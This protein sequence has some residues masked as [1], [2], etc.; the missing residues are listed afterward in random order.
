MRRAILLRKDSS[1]EGTFGQIAA[2]KIVLFTGEL[3]NRDNQPSI[4]CIPEG[5]YDVIWT[6]SP[7]FSRMMYLIANVPSRT[8][9]RKHSANLMGDVLK[10]LKSQLNGCIA[11]GEK[12][13]WIDKQ[14]ALLLSVPA[15]RRF[16]EA[17]NREPFKLEIRYA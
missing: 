1:D 11:L 5:E 17:M 12:L 3:P 2:A 4:S 13:G 7:R 6:W 16:E 15:V 10:G 8:G 9:V 14:K